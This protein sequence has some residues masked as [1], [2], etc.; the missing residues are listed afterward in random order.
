MTTFRT[1]DSITFCVTGKSGLGHLRRTA[2]IAAALN[3]ACADVELR[4]VVNAPVDGLGLGERGLFAQT[5]TVDRGDMARCVAELPDGPV[6]CDTAVIPDI[7]ML[8]R[9]LVLVLRE[10]VEARL[11][12]FRMPAGRLWDEVIVAEPQAAWTAAAATV[13][14]AR[15]HNVGWIYRMPPDGGARVLPSRRD[16]E[17][18]ILIATG[19]GGTAATA[20]ALKREIDAVLERVLRFAGERPRVV[21]VIGPR[22]PCE[23]RLEHADEIVDVGSRLDAAFTEADLVVSTAGYN[24]V[25]E[26]A[27]TE[28]PTLLCAIARTYD[29][30]VGRAQ[31]WG[32]RLGLAHRQG[33]VGR[34]ARWIVETLQTGRRR[35]MVTLGPCG[36]ERAAER[37]LLHAYQP[38]DP[39]ASFTKAI[40]SA[41]LA[42][43]CPLPLRSRVLFVRGVPT[44]PGKAGA[45]RDSVVFAR[46]EGPTATQEW[47]A[48]GT[49]EHGADAR[50]RMAGPIAAALLRLHRAGRAG[51]DL[52]WLDAWRRV[53]PRLAPDAAAARVL[54]SG[55]LQSIGT[56]MARLSATEL[57]A[58]Q[59][60]G[61]VHGDFHLGQLIRLRGGNGFVI[62]DL[63]DLA[64]GPPEADIANCAAHIA[65]SPHLHRGP[66]ELGARDLLDLLG[67]AYETAAG[68]RLDQRRLFWHAATNLLRRVLK[69]AERTGDTL[70]ADETIAAA[71]HFASGGAASARRVHLA[72]VA[73]SPP[74]SP[75]QWEPCHE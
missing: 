40:H 18:R 13:G 60:Y 74:P 43:R 42:A 57:P 52:P 2:N 22:A 33:D 47:A 71:A 48:L 1:R 14:A 36:S 8:P 31:A 69:R 19:G 28:T 65:T 37:L 29:D 67:A 4:L 53:R 11:G 59:S 10:T 58:S 30:Q 61:L 26:L 46:L 44:P 32:D 24:S 38:L 7:E 6:V 54:G 72:P 63:D 75:I 3:R 16:G 39:A 34:S 41:E 56:T 68:T 64:L 15:V 70:A 55:R 51:L 9:R 12:A 45:S 73:S 62:V 35:P 23:A 50:R 21:Q 49:L 17:K 66:V 27:T 20:A 25:L 5:C